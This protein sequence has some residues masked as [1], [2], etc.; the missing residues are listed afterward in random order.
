MELFVRAKLTIERG[1]GQP[2]Q[3]Q[4]RIPDQSSASIG[5]EN[6]IYKFSSNHAN[7]LRFVGNGPFGLRLFALC[8]I[9]Q[10][11]PGQSFFSIDVFVGRVLL[12]LIQ[13][14]GCDINFA[15]TLVVLVS[16]RSAARA[17][18]RSPCFSTG[19]E[20]LGCSFRE[21]E[22]RAPHGD[23]CHSLSPGRAPAISAVTICL[24][25]CFAFRAEPHSPAITPA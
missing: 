4:S 25:E 13:A 14:A 11:H 20:P 8:L 5:T 17:A 6:A 24:M 10:W 12:R 2:P 19:A 16:E 18:K 22:S 3:R 7:R 1:G 23:P 15:R 9:D 21:L